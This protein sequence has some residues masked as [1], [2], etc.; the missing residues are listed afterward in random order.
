M[1]TAPW[2]LIVLAGGGG[3][4]L[5]GI[6]KAAILLDGRSLLD[7]LLDAVPPDVDVIVSGRPRP[8]GRPVTFV[9]EDPPDGGPVAGIAAALPS[10]RT[11]LVAVV[12]VDMPWAGP[13]L[14]RLVT[15]LVSSEQEAMLTRDPDGHHQVLCAAWRTDALTRAIHAL[16]SPRDRAVRELLVGVDVDTVPVTPLAVLDVDTPEDLARARDAAAPPTL[17][18]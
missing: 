11:P 14:A 2:S 7:R 15:A 1:T 3:T 10:V 17:D 12:A 4:R 16:G 13:I 5:G 6:D 9:L 18:G 8:I